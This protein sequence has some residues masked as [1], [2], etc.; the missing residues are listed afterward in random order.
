VGG[1]TC[2]V[3]LS[4]YPDVDV[5]VYEAAATFTA[6]G[7]GVGVWLRTWRILQQLGLDHELADITGTQM[8]DDPG[9]AVSLFFRGFTSTRLITRPSRHIQYSEKRLC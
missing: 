2:A 1:L 8:S 4:K 9:E 3:A 7:P 6:N 5:D